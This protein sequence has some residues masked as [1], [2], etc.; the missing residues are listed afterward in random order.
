MT[1]F[2]FAIVIVVLLVCYPLAT[3]YAVTIGSDTAVNRFTTQVTLNNADVV[4]SFAN[5]EAGFNIFGINSNALFRAVFPVGGLISLRQAMLTLGTDLVTQENS[6][7]ISLGTIVGNDYKFDLSHSITLIPAV[8]DNIFH[9][10]ANFV[11]SA[12]QLSDVETCDWSYDNQFLA[13]GLE[14][15]GAQH[16]LLL[17][18]RF[19]GTAL[20]LTDSSLLGQYQDLKSVRWHPTKHFLAVTRKQVGAALNEILIMSVNPITGLLT[21]VSGAK[22]SAD[23]PACAWHPSGNFLATSRFINLAEIAIYAVNGS[24]IISGPVATADFTP[25]RNPRDEALGWDKTG[26]YLGIGLTNNMT[27]PTLL[28]YQFNSI[29]PSLTLNASIDTTGIVQGVD[30]NPTTT[31][32]IGIVRSGSGQQLEIYRHNPTAPIVSNRLMKVTGASLGA[33]GT[34][35]AWNSDG[36][37]IATGKETAGTGEFR[38]YEFDATDVSLSLVSSFDLTDIVRTTRWAPSGAFVAQGND[39]NNVSVYQVNANNDAD[40]TFFNLAFLIGADLTIKKSRIHFAGDCVMNGRG[41]ILTLAPTCTFIVD[42]DA[43]LLLQDIVIKG[44][45]S[46]KIQCVDSS[47]TLSCDNAVFI[48]D[49]NFSF[50]RGR[51]DVIKDFRISGSGYN[52]SYET[53]QALNIGPASS[54]TIDRGTI[55]TYQPNNNNNQLLQFFD[56]S[57]QLILRDCIL[58]VADSGLQLM[59]GTVIID[60]NTHLLSQAVNQSQGVIVGDG[61]NGNNNCCV[62]WV[63]ESGLQIDE[64]WFIYNNVAN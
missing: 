25:D 28:V 5:L 42:E 38:I 56:R 10:D 27:N 59:Q 9:C 46:N 44:I 61:V 53:D 62:R 14:T 37:C 51:L 4:A 45:N 41:N 49:G 63:G 43:T 50:T 60:G 57:S 13:V 39:A 2:K 15:G 26:T 48:L 20:T 1:M 55:F 30:W 24:G 3:I 7:I 16:N 47:S 36:G 12:A 11:V 21:Q 64:G 18:Y 34:A 6:N 31:N 52:F 19:N 54:L 23:V 33:N 17:I 8:P 29:V 58:S 40:I 35:V 22:V 32:M